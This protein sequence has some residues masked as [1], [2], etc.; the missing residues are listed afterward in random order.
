MH[1]RVRMLYIYYEIGSMYRI[2][3]RRATSWIVSTHFHTLLRPSPHLHV[4]TLRPGATPE[5]MYPLTRIISKSRGL[6][7]MYLYMHLRQ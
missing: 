1:L 2:V 3:A 6:L 4:V 7:T 5:R